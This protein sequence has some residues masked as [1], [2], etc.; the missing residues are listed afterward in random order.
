[1]RQKINSQKNRSRNAALESQEKIQQRTPGRSADGEKTRDLRKSH[2]RSF[3]VNNVGLAPQERD[4]YSF[5][6]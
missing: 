3:A 2:P 6:R 1:M 5:Q 4:V